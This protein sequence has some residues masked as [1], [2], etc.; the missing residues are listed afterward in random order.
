MYLCLGKKISIATDLHRGYDGHAR[1]IR[2]LPRRSLHPISR[3]WF[4]LHIS[5]PPTNDRSCFSRYIPM[6][7]YKFWRHLIPNFARAELGDFVQ[8]S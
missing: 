3:K 7:D 4:S 1:R 6:R 8:G 2:R 5:H